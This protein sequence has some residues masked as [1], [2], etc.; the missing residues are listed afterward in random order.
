[1]QGRSQTL[2]SVKLL[3]FIRHTLELL[4]SLLIACSHC[5][6]VERMSSHQRRRLTDQSTNH[7]ELT[8]LMEHHY[9]VSLLVNYSPERSIISNSPLRHLCTTETNDDNKKNFFF[10]LRLPLMRKTNINN[11]LAIARSPCSARSFTL[12]SRSS[13]SHP[14]STI[15]R[16]PELAFET[17]GLTIMFINLTKLFGAKAFVS[18]SASC[19][20]V[21][22]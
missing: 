2:G 16:I 7:T 11:Q 5:T 19:S 10:S 21:G 6:G 22:M 3:V 9:S 1:M 14:T 13:A 20:P 12:R 8:Q 17:P 4:H 18:R 15:M